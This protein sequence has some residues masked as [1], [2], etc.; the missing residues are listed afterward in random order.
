MWIESRQPPGLQRLRFYNPNL[1]AL[2][3]SPVKFL[4][5]AYQAG[6]DIAKA[7]VQTVV[8]TPVAQS[9]P[10]LSPAPANAQ[11][12]V[13]FPHTIAQPH[14]TTALNWFLGGP[15]LNKGTPRWTNDANEFLRSALVDSNFDA[16][17]KWADW[18]VASY[19]PDGSPAK[20]APL[21]DR[22]LASDKWTLTNSGAKIYLPF[23]E[24]D[25]NQFIEKISTYYTKGFRKGAPRGRGSQIEDVKQLFLVGGYTPMLNT[26][27]AAAKLPQGERLT[28]STP[29]GVFK[30]GYI[31]QERSHT[32]RN[33]MVA[34]GAA[35]IGGAALQAL[36]TAYFP[37][38]T[39]KVTSALAKIPQNI[40][41]AASVISNT[42]KAIPSSV[43]NV[44]TAISP[45]VGKAVEAVAP[46]VKNLAQDYVVNEVQKEIINAATR[47]DQREIERLMA[48]LQA[49]EANIRAQLMAF[50]PTGQTPSGLMITPQPDTATQ[51]AIQRQK[52]QNQALMIAAVGLTLLALTTR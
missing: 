29:Y 42:V 52:D 30:V 15:I 26:I 37:V 7:P 27:R 25:L 24:A 41:T 40:R 50:T 45:T 18:W 23:S 48:G 11:G 51:I 17:K 36:G 34:T 35:V 2:S 44:A 20:M 43:K 33:V 9:Y 22:N 5:S 47:G 16:V 49:E 3:G 19:A 38:Q 28:R 46:V 13:P 4:T 6:I 39:A 14:Q 10:A 21:Y 8:T 31:P 1:G 32:L 12:A